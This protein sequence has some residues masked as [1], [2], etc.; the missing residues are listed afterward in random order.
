M[1]VLPK[2]VM[3]LLAAT[4][5]VVGQADPAPAG[6]DVTSIGGVPPALVLGGPDALAF[7]LRAAGEQLAAWRYM[8]AKDP[9]S[10]DP[11]APDPASQDPLRREVTV[12]RYFRA[13][14]GADGQRSSAASGQVGKAPDTSWEKGS[15]WASSSSHEPAAAD[16]PLLRSDDLT[17]EKISRPAAEAQQRP[18]WEGWDKAPRAGDQPWD[19][20]DPDGEQADFEALA[21][22]AAEEMSGEKGE[23]LSGMEGTFG[24]ASISLQ[25]LNGFDW[26]VISIILGVVALRMG[27]GRTCGQLI[28]LWVARCQGIPV[29]A[30]AGG[31]HSQRRR[32]RSA[33]PSFRTRSSRG[34]R[35]PWSPYQVRPSP[36]RTRG[37]RRRPAAAT[38]PTGARP[39]RGSR[40][41]V[42]A[43]V[44]Y[45]N[46][47]PVAT[48]GRS[49]AGGLLTC[50]RE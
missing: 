47:G 35:V 41:Y 30:V 9:T 11:L 34:R 15:L 27:A 19:D 39:H 38:Y 5:L 44:V 49:P 43:D 8:A 14:G 50:V 29:A 24:G 20:V 16:V 25:D 18:S 31:Y 45:T 10:P 36:R 13:G 7:N 40:E 26:L 17:A 22:V 1:N 48:A 46:T 33:R 2:S 32:R 23:A 3:C 21:G 4:M 12:E 6:D 42:V 28:S 37:Q